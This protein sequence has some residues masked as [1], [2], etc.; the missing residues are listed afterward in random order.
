MTRFSIILAMCISLSAEASPQMSGVVFPGLSQTEYVSIFSSLESQLKSDP[1]GSANELMRIIQDDTQASAHG[2]AFGLLAEA[3]RNM[4]LAYSATVLYNKAFQ[5]DMAINTKRI[6]NAIAQAEQVSRPSL[7]GQ[8]FADQYGNIN[9]SQSREAVAYEAAKFAQQNGNFA[10]ANAMISIVPSEANQFGQIKNLEGIILANQG[11]AEGAVVPLLISE[12]I[13]LRDEDNELL[14]TA[15][16][17]LARAYFAAGNFPRAVDYYSEVERTSAIWADA[18]FEQAWAYFRMND[19]NSTLSM[20]HT[21]QSPFLE[22]FYYPE[23]ELLRIYALFVMCKFPSAATE[24]DRFIDSNTPKRDKLDA[25]IQNTPSNIFDQ[26]RSDIELLTDNVPFLIRSRFLKDARLKKAFAAEDY[27]T[28]ELS[29]L[30]SMPQDASVQIAMD[31]IN[32]DLQQLKIDEG[33]RILSQAQF[34]AAELQ[35]MLADAEMHK[36]DILEMEAQMLRQASITGKMEDAKRVIQRN[37]RLKNNERTWPYQGEY[38]AD[39]LGYYRIKSK[40]ECPASMFQPK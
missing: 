35:Q 20:L 26:I 2:A 36:L 14:N 22:S 33:N 28:K 17:N 15:R 38:W 18:H 21:H 6:P 12:Q 9:S 3:F 29:K 19:M 5:L 31:S 40:P 8:S 11:N 10:L 1:S 4:G 24:T 37:K 30:S 16:I 7:L 34:M 32:A 13:A 23:A 27:A 39:E 25:F